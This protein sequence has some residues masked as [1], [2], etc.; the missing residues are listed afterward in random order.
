MR[1][2]LQ[3]QLQENQSSKKLKKLMLKREFKIKDYLHKSSRLI[4][5]TLIN[6]KIG[7]LIIGHNE[8]WK[9][10]INLGKRNNQNFVSVSYNKLI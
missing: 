9:Q 4:I 5:N 7:T 8:E 3:S 6:Q 1:S 2:F 10:K